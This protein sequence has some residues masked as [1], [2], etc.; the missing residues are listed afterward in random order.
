LTKAW[1]TVDLNKNP[2]GEIKMNVELRMHQVDS[3]DALPAYVERRFQLKLG[4]HAEHVRKLKLRLTEQESAKGCAAKLCFVAAELV[5]SGELVVMETSADPYMAISGAIER[6]KTALLRKVDRQ[7]SAR[8][9]R[10]SVRSPM[11]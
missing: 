11:R 3:V 4:R 10:Q 1:T 9:G 8:R 7:R 2:A 5:P 6:F